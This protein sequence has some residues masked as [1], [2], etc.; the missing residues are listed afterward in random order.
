M[1][2]NAPYVY[3][4]DQIS[5]TSRVYTAPRSVIRAYN[6]H[7]VPAA[8]QAIEKALAEG[9]Y[10]AGYAAYELGYALDKKLERLISKSDALP[11]LE[12]GVFDEFKPASPQDND[13]SANARLPALRPAWSQADYTSRFDTLLAYISAG[14]IYQANL[15]FPYRGMSQ[16]KPDLSALYGQLRG[17][18][19]VRYGAIVSLGTRDILSLSPELFFS[20]EDGLAKARPMKGT[21]PRGKTPDEDAAIGRAMQADEKS[22]AENLMIVD[23]L[24]NDLSR[25]SKP[26]SVKVT[27]L[28]SLET[29]PTLHQMTSGIEALL[30]E[31]VSITDVFARLFPCGSVTG[32]PK[33]RAME[34]IR[35]LEDRPRG[36]YC[37]AI[38]Y[39]DP[40]GN[41]NFNVAI[42]T[43]T[44]TPKDGGY[45]LEYNVGSGVVYDSKAADEYAECLLKARIVTRQAPQLIETFK[46]TQAQGFD[47]LEGHCLRLMKAADK[48][49]YPINMANIMQALDESVS[50]ARN[51]QRVR[52]TLSA[53]GQVDVTTQTLYTL[54]TPMRLC[55]N[56]AIINSSD[57]AFTLK[58]SPMPLY[59]AARADV[60]ARKDCDE[61]IFVN[62]HGHVTEGSFTNIFVK[63]GK[64]WLTP[65]LTDGLLPGVLRADLL[66]T[67]LAIEAHLSLKDLQNGEL[68]VGNSVRGLMPAVLTIPH[69]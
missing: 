12:F 18:Q 2:D 38:G 29:F 55:V 50:K 64:V 62:E 68:Y 36:A 42:R 20:V 13:E 28:F 49:D 5:G 1:S 48:L 22:R 19:P 10:V 66:N 57:P 7:D 45:A 34:I 67:G 39:F 17:R 56:D 65:P 9:Y 59:D 41:C 47:Y 37:G 54:K 44:S 11:L 6:T 26:G 60:K 46:W 43:L 35:E 53:T 14:D 15:T 3:L 58:T 27:D 31:D 33:I 23:L 25:V 21:A 8:F 51:D 4:D 32:A 52:L 40:N 69:A 30:S 63:R 61:L 16:T 24:R